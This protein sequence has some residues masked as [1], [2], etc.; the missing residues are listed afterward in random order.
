LIKAV[1]ILTDRAEFADVVLHILAPTVSGPWFE[2]KRA[3]YG[4][5]RENFKI[6]GFL[7]PPDLA[8]L[9]QEVAIVASPTISDGTPNSMLEAMACG[10]FPVMSD[11]ESNREWIAAG[12]NGL[13]FDPNDPQD[14]AAKLATALDDIS[15]RQEAQ[16]IN[17]N[18]VRKRVDYGRVMP[19]VRQFYQRLIKS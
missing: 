4:L 16:R 2:E 1:R 12:E 10:A 14:L 6:G 11:L 17:Y 9:L 13:T 18:I 3:K 7:A 5:P 15:L 19:A 8:R